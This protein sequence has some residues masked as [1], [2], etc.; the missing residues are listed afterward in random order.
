MEV[1]V[2]QRM[3]ELNTMFIIVSNTVFNFSRTLVN[4][5]Q[6]QGEKKPAR[7][8]LVRYLGEK[9]VQCFGDGFSVEVRIGS[10]D[11]VRQR[12]KEPR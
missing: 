5:P 4:S 9:N 2:L 1:R 12:K 6:H 8:G 3:S 11:E 10:Q 7:G